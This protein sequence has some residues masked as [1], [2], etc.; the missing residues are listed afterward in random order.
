MILQWLQLGFRGYSGLCIKIKGPGYWSN[1]V[2]ISHMWLV[3]LRHS[4]FVTLVI[5]QVLNCLCM[6]ATIL[7]S[8]DRNISIM[9]ESSVRQH[10]STA[11]PKLL[12]AFL[13][14]LNQYTGWEPG[15]QHCLLMPFPFLLL[16]MW[17]LCNSGYVYLRT[18]NL[19]AVP[20]SRT[21]DKDEYLPCLWQLAGSHRKKMEN[22][23]D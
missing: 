15:L 12:P 9:V 18:L 16:V 2:V 10:W 20:C 6:V 11:I 21:D 22:F 23:Q 17:D 3:K 8:T 4:F 1:P 5:F 7:H 14:V 13:H 19:R